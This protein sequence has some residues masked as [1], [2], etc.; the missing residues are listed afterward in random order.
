MKRKKEPWPRIGTLVALKRTA[1]YYEPPRKW[2]GIPQDSNV[3]LVQHV[4][5]RDGCTV[6]NG[7]WRKEEVRPL[8]KRE[9]DE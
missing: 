2:N 4:E 7:W 6:V 5:K 1:R 3:M 8:T 9:K